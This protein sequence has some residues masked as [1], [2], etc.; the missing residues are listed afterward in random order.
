MT[1]PLRAVLVV[2]LST[3]LGPRC[4]SA[5]PASCDRLTDLSIPNTVIASAVREPSSDVCSV[6]LIS[7]PVP[8]SEIGVEIWL[9]PAEKWNGKFLGTGNGGYS[10]DLSYSAMKSALE[11]GYAVAGSDT[12]HQGGDLK[13]GSGHPEKIDDWGY[14]AVHIMTETAKLVI[15][16]YYGRFA[17]EAYFS[18]CST[19]GHQALSEAQRYP[20]DY[21]G[22]LAGDPGN[23]RVRLNVGFLWSWKATNGGP[24]L[25]FPPSKLPM[26]NKAVIAACDE[27]DG[28]RDGVIGDPSGCKFDPSSLLCKGAD[29]PACLTASEAAAVR[30]VYDGAHNPRTGERLYAGWVPGSEAGWAGYFVGHP[31]PARLDFWRYWVFDN[32]AW[33]PLTF[34][35]DRDVA[36]TDTKMAA[37][38]A[39]ESDL[40]A[41]E[42]HKGK[43]ILYQ[44]WADPV[45]PPDDTIR[46]FESVEKAMG[47]AHA[48]DFMRLFMVPGMGHCGGGPGSASFDALSALDAWVSR[49]VAPDRIT[50]A[51]LQNGVASY[52]RPLCPFP[53][54]A[55]PRVQGSTDKA[56][57]FVCSTGAIG[58]KG[59]RE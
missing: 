57:D 1:I 19:G 53:Q 25:P 15:R 46:Y 3:A 20:S 21:D 51:H 23:N 39:N 8:D 36:Y 49:N 37:V 9:P 10:G 44:G 22:I 30:K 6:K 35:F 24:E 27:L 17:A 26:L 42:Q 41:F 52:T 54:V 2:A 5:T 12:G 18:G 40:K 7:R 58:T 32:T 48:R 33:D 38:I 50:A 55:R 28:V 31:E 45:V 47:R 14:R 13:F 34:D 4:L 43:L 16:N 29:G 56:E 59:R 11:K